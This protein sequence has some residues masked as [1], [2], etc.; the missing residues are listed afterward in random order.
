MLSHA[1]KPYL[2][3]QNQFSALLIFII[4]KILGNYET[5]CIGFIVEVGE[6]IK[7]RYDF[8]NS[9]QEFWFDAIYSS[10]R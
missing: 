6:L 7:I 8:H 3:H 1:Q 2:T 4:L 9:P 5:T 10:G